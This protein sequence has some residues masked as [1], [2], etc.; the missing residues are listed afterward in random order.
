VSELRK[1]VVGLKD[2]LSQ[3]RREKNSVDDKLRLSIH[4]KEHLHEQLDSQRV[5]MTNALHSTRADLEQALR[6]DAESWQQQVHRREEMIQDL[7]VQLQ[8]QEAINLKMAAIERDC[9]ELQ[10]ELNTSRQYIVSLMEAS[11]KIG[12][13]SM[14]T[15]GGYSNVGKAWEGLHR[16]I[17][18][19]PW[20]KE[21]GLDRLV[22]HEG[23]TSA[24]I[25]G[26]EDT[27]ASAFGLVTGVSN[28]KSAT[29]NKVPRFK[30]A[31][32]PV[33]ADSYGQRPKSARKDGVTPRST[34]PRTPRALSPKTP[35]PL[36]ARDKV[37][38]NAATPRSVSITEPITP[39]AK[40]PRR[41]ESISFRNASP[42]RERPLS[43]RQSERGTPRESRMRPA[44]SAPVP[45]SQRL[46]ECASRL[47]FD[48][49]KPAPKENRDAV[50]GRQEFS[51]GRFTSDNDSRAGSSY[52]S[53]GLGGY[54]RQGMLDNPSGRDR[55]L[56]RPDLNKTWMGLLK[57]SRDN[58]RAESLGSG[59]LAIR[60]GVAGANMRST[61]AW[62]EDS[63]ERGAVCFCVSMT[64]TVPIP[65]SFPFLICAP[66]F[67]CSWASNEYPILSNTGFATPILSSPLRRAHGRWLSE[68]PHSAH[69]DEVHARASRLH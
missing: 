29:G 66:V 9:H 27:L 22:E 23:F 13:F 2:E 32:G 59:Q 53:S 28:E 34:T 61:V 35:R 10:E 26:G 51:T 58:G 54:S 7:E 52:F 41:E 39:R 3:L 12:H 1:S 4:E 55:E 64:I 36:S 44:E 60:G 47:R 69:Q 37:T 50:R 33:F 8:D 21:M 65:V 16:Y 15:G 19:T 43:S 63:P 20:G 38:G 46:Q 40:T 49:R 5:A 17:A 11:A 42:P 62:S 68:D 6:D 67:L 24:T 48:S 56:E 45:V 25:Q 14:R 31:V 18:S 30:V 57:S